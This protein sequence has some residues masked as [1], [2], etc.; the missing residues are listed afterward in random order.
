L[1][2]EANRVPPY[3]TGDPETPDPEPEHAVPVRHP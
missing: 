1:Q 3:D 2:L